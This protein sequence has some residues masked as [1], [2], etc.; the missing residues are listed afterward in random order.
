[1]VQELGVALFNG[2]LLLVVHVL[3]RSLERR[4]AHHPRDVLVREIVLAGPWITRST[5]E[6]RH[7]PR[8]LLGLYR[9]YGPVLHV[10]R[11]AKRHVAFVPALLRLVLVLVVGTRPGLKRSC[12]R[13]LLVLEP[14]LRSPLLLVF[15]SLFFGLSELL[16][17]ED[18]ETY[19]GISSNSYC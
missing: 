4:L 13:E 17:V 5:Y 8:S 6:G 18:T 7:V 15:H 12:A 9:K 19:N 11:R 10:G 3:V 16:F 2:A 14:A 1:M